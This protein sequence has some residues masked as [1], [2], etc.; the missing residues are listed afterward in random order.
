M[1]GAII[2]IYSNEVIEQVRMANEIVALISSYLPLKQKGNNYFGLCPF[3]NEKSPSFCVSSERQMYHC[4]GCGASG[5]VFTFIMQTENYNFGEAVRFLAERANYTLPEFKNDEADKNLRYKNKLIE[6]NAVAARHFYHN[7]T[8]SQFA[9]QYLFDRNISKTS[10][11]KF[12]LGYAKSDLYNHLLAKGYEKKDILAAGLAVENKSGKILDRFFNRIMF[13]IFNIY[14]KII[15][16]GARTIND[17]KPKYLN[18]PETILFNKS[19]NLYN[20]NLACKSKS[21]QL[22]LTEGYID[23]ISVFQAGCENVCA[24]LG[25]AFNIKHARL[26]KN[27]FDSVILLFDSDEAGIKAI[28]RA[29]PILDSVGIE[30][31]VLQLPNAKDPDEYIKK[32]GSDSFKNLLKN[33]VNSFDFQVNNV[34]KKYDLNN[35]ADKV[36]FTKETAQIISGLNDTIKKEIYINEISKSMQISSDILKNELDKFEPFEF[37]FENK[38]INSQPPIDKAKSD[39]INIVAKNPDI[40]PQIEKYLPPDDLGG[41]VYSKLLQLIY[42]FYNTSSDL[43]PATLINYFE[44]PVEQS[45]AAEIL[46]N[47]VAYDD[48]QKALTDIIKIIKKYNVAQKI[49]AVNDMEDLKALLSEKKTIEHFEFRKD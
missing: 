31:K 13:P 15:G 3:H 49:S 19:T 11:K 44:L 40:Y 20:I 4:F 41:G 34:K 16:F 33:S 29:I 30:S 43:N 38:K 27:H 24:A 5:N 47:D 25:T 42:S 39:F 36:K 35:P 23:V 37:K 2:M 1:F 7:L 48:I 21:K 17:S 26:I 45:L 32:F 22:I 46:N 18:S 12:G 10:I 6:M 14:G 8:D 9:L 28:L